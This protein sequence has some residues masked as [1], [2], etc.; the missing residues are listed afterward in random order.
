MPGD[1]E[2]NPR[3]K[4]GFGRRP[5]SSRAPPSRFGGRSGFRGR[6]EAPDSISMDL[7]NLLAIYR[8]IREEEQERDEVLDSLEIGFD[9]IDACV[10]AEGMDQDK[11]RETI[12]LVDIG[13]LIKILRKTNYS[14][15]DKFM[16]YL[17]NL[18]YEYY[19]DVVYP[20]LIKKYYLLFIFT[21]LN[22]IDLD[23]KHRA[24]F[25]MLFKQIARKVGGDIKSATKDIENFG[26]STIRNRG[27]RNRL[28]NRNEKQQP[29][30]ETEETT[31]LSVEEKDDIR[32][33]ILEELEESDFD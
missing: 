26:K 17:A 24:D 30:E 16:K 27:L 1:F 10:K 5:P 20:P 19:D 25:L 7:E 2:E 13:D 9:L 18:V 21:Y 31:S 22:R 32:R 12:R 33:D 3:P 28:F 11:A 15:K 29:K 8:L 23:S 6:Y 4:G 14:R